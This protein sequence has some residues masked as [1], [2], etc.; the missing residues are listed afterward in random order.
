MVQINAQTQHEKGKQ[1]HLNVMQQVAS[2]VAAQ[3]ATKV[4]KEAD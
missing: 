3:Q 4:H 2:E 1:Q